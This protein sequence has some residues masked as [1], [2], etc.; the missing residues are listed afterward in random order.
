MDFMQSG[1]SA[2]ELDAEITYGEQLSK[3]AP[4]A[5]IEAGQY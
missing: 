3:E 5:A 2:G 1:R 4:T